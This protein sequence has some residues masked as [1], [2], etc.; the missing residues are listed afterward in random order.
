MRTPLFR[1]R[2]SGGFLWARLGLL[3]V[4]ALVAIDLDARPVCRTGVAP[5]LAA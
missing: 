5:G 4:S 3:V 1:Y 2:T